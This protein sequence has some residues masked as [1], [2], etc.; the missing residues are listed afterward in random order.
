MG[1]YFLVLKWAG[2]MYVVYVLLEWISLYPAICVDILNN[3]YG[4]RQGNWAQTKT[5]EGDRES[6]G[7]YDHIGLLG[8]EWNNKNIQTK[9]R[10]S[11]IIHAW[12]SVIIR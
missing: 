12:E 9:Y 6:C 5:T 11:K 8:S 2:A 7:R 3:T 4:W 1:C 10:M